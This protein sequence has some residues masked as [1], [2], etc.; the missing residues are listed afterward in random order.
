MA[1]E[2]ALLERKG[3]KPW[4]RKGTYADGVIGGRRKNQHGTVRRGSLLEKQGEI[5]E[6]EIKCC[7][8][9]QLANDLAQGERK[10]YRR[11]AR[12][13]LPRR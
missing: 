7:D 6:K 2:P 12:N 1:I 13:A 10:D 4:R 11:R 5:E 3:G 9:L 8:T